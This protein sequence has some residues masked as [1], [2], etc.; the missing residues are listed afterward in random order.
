MMLMMSYDVDNITL[1]QVNIAR[2]DGRGG[3]EKLHC[4]MGARGWGA[5]HGL[6]G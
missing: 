5:L 4:M 1:V 3:L 6:M 2:H